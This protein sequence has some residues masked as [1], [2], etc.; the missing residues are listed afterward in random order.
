MST[1]SNPILTADEVAQRT[2][3]A[4]FRALRIL[5]EIRQCPGLYE[6]VRESRYTHS[7]HELNRELS[8]WFSEDT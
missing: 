3:R 1:Q 6:Q 7:L 4:V 8:L 5:T 2:E